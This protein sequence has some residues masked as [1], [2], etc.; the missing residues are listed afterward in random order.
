MADGAQ[1]RRGARRRATIEQ[2]LDIALTLMEADG[3]AGVTVAAIARELGIQPPSVYRYFSS[4]LDI[5]DALFARGQRENL[6]AFRGAVDAGPPGLPAVVAGMEA[7][8]RWAVAHPALAQ[9]L[10]WRPVPGYRPTPEA[11]AP[12]EALVG[13]LGRQLRTAVETGQVGAGADSDA[14]MDLLSVLYFGMLSQQ[15]ANEPGAPWESGRYT[16]R[17]GTVVRLFLAAYPPARR[18]DSP[19]PRP[20]RARPPAAPRRRPRSTGSSSPEG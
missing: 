16:S 6:A 13:L 19:G 20:D 2:I 7:N 17:F 12:A 14:G 10:F 18:T 8:G 3:V 4:L 9:L 1:D 5:Y 11:F 15:L